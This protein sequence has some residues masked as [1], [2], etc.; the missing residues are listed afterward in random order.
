MDYDECV[1]YY[2]ETGNSRFYGDQDG[3]RYM[4]TLG[5]YEDFYTL[6]EGDVP[7]DSSVVSGAMKWYAV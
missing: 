4:M 7:V 6:E 3:V 1:E 5:D 2:E